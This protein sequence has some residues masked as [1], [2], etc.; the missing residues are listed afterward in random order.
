MAHEHIWAIVSEDQSWEKR[1]AADQLI[2]TKNPSYA[3][4][5]YALAYFFFVFI[6]II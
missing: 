2:L 1:L 5:L 4:T 6:H 3:L